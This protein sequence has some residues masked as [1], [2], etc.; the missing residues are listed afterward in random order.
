MRLRIDG[1]AGAHHADDAEAAGRDPR[2]GV[3]VLDHQGPARAAGRPF[4][5]CAQRRGEDGISRC[6]IVLEPD[7]VAVDPRPRGPFQGWRYFRACGCAAGPRLRSAEA[8]PICRYEL[9]REL[10]VGFSRSL[11]VVRPEPDG[12]VRGR[13]E[14]HIARQPQTVTATGVRPPH[15]NRIVGSA[16]GEGH[17]DRNHG[18]PILALRGDRPVGRFPRAGAGP[19]YRRAG[20]LDDT[21]LFR[22]APAALAYADMVAA[23]DRYAAAHL[24]EG[25]D[26]DQEASRLATSLPRGAIASPPSVSALPT[27]EFAARPPA[28]ATPGALRAITRVR[29]ERPTLDL[30]RHHLH[31]RSVLLAARYRRSSPNCRSQVVPTS[32][33]SRAQRVRAGTA[34]RKRHG[35]AK[36]QIIQM[37]TGPVDDLATLRRVSSPAC[38]ACRS[39]RAAA[40]RACDD[41]KGAAARSLADR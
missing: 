13:A 24:D 11:R 4:S 27:T 31:Q 9:Q 19:R 29:A 5:T 25:D 14:A 28:S 38:A 32:T 16:P 22:T 26:E 41:S 8:M 2:G 23:A 39:D 10:R 21:T 17:V 3:A 40:P 12:R 34:G 6:D 20:R 30:A 37:K 35:V 36:L 7:V 1:R 15:P 33:R 18:R